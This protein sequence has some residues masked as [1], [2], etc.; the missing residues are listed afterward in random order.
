[1][2][3]SLFPPGNTLMGAFQPASGLL[4]RSLA[5]SCGW[6]LYKRRTASSR[7][8]AEVASAGAASPMDAPQRAAQA[9][10]SNSEKE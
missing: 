6:E 9:W 1:M 8:N 5:G 3:K 4:S 7:R 10:V 2:G